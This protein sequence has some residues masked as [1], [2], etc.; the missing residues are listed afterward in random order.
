MPFSWQ[1][2]CQDI[3]PLQMDPTATEQKQSTALWQHYLKSTGF[4]RSQKEQVIF[5]QRGNV[6]AG[7]HL[8]HTSKFSL[9]WMSCLYLHPFVSSSSLLQLC[10]CSLGCSHY[11][12]QQ[13]SRRAELCLVGCSWLSGWCSSPLLLCRGQSGC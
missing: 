10:G 5:W 7:F 11:K 8:H 1:L 4:G 9:F 3:R 12:C 6:S 2:L 13:S